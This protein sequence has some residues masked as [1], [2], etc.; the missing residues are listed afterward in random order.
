MRAYVW[1]PADELAWAVI[2]MAAG[3]LTAAILT[4]RQVLV[5]DALPVAVLIGVM[6]VL[7]LAL[8]ALLSWATTPHG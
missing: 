3:G 8:G 7:R 2:V 5:P 6:G 1:R 4:W